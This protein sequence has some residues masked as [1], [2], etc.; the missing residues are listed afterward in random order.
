MIKRLD[1]IERKLF[2]NLEIECLENRT[3]TGAD[4]KI[5]LAG[6][7]MHSYLKLNSFKWEVGP[8]DWNDGNGR[9]SL[10][11]N[12]KG[13]GIWFTDLGNPYII[14]YPIKRMEI[15]TKGF[16]IKS[17]NTSLNT[18]LFYKG[19]DITSMIALCNLKYGASDA[20]HINELIL[21]MV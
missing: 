12:I 5:L 8:V 13:D 15:S 16:T 2:S 21:E 3:H 14:D 1:K 10:F 4:C 19:E 18:K 17:D 7:P 6:L 20:E 9:I 11:Y